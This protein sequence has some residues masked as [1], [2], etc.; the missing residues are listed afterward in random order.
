MNGVVG[1][2][3]KKILCLLSRSDYLLIFIFNRLFCMRNYTSIVNKIFL[4][5]LQSS[6][7]GCW[8]ACMLPVL[9]LT[10]YLLAGLLNAYDAPVCRY[11]ILPATSGP[12]SAQASALLNT[13]ICKC[14]FYMLLAFSLYKFIF[15][16]FTFSYIYFFIF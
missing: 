14:K 1:K 15:I 7:L 3:I 9:P 2:K 5:F 4:H 12:A 6:D 11:H 8:A 13:T 16:P 10:Q